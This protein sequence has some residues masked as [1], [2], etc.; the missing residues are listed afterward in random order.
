MLFR[1]WVKFALVGATS[2]TTFLSY[3]NDDDDD[4]DYDSNNIHSE[5]VL[6]LSNPSLDIVILHLITFHLAHVLSDDCADEG[7]RKRIF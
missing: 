1:L 4:D 6:D 7:S 2:Y 5:F 3:I